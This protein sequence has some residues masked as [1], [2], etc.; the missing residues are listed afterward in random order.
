MAWILCFQELFTSA[1][2]WEPILWREIMSVRTLGKTSDCQ[3]YHQIFYKNK[4]LN[5]NSETKIQSG[6]K[7][8]FGCR[9]SSASLNKTK[10]N[11]TVVYFSMACWVTL[12]CCQ[13]F[14]QAEP[15]YRTSKMFWVPFFWSIIALQ[16]CVYAVQWNVSAICIH[17][18]P[19]SWISFPPYPH[20]TH[21]GCHGALSWTP[22]KA[23]SSAG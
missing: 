21:L 4:R 23:M 2:L 9:S 10:I 12:V 15:T 3:K 17:I 19:P 20:P 13:I 18:S 5:L 22:C 6:S 7:F 16:C 11:S 14:S 1:W 8:C